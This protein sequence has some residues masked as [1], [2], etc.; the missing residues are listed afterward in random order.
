M[1][2]V[3]TVQATEEKA[4]PKV[5]D[6]PE[7]KDA[8]RLA[9]SKYQSATAEAKKGVKQLEGRVRQLS[10]EIE[11]SKQE[12]EVARLAGD[13]PDAADIAKKLLLLRTELEGSAKELEEREERVSGIERRATIRMLTEEYGISSEDL[14]SLDSADEMEKAAMKFKLNALSKEPEKEPAEKSPGHDVGRGQ[15]VAGP[16]WIAK[17]LSQDPKDQAEFEK[18]VMDAKSRR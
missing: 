15:M 3:K 17:A 2:E 12:A 13:D 7:F 10:T 11:Q 1:K 16:S 9:T 14:D 8:L 6:T 18:K 5:Q 4:Q